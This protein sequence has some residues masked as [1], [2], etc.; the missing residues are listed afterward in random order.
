MT[1]G[2]AARV[3]LC[4]PS[5]GSP[6]HVAAPIEDIRDEMR[7]VTRRNEAPQARGRR[8][9]DHG[10]GRHRPLDPHD[11]DITP[12]LEHRKRDQET[13]ERVLVAV[14]EFVDID[15]ELPDPGFIREKRDDARAFPPTVCGLQVPIDNRVELLAA[16]QGIRIALL[17]DATQLV[18]TTRQIWNLTAFGLT[19]TG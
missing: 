10:R 17:A 11:V 12:R 13:E 1:T 15:R 16:R 6:V 3:T 14:P 19:A 7:A 5:T 18:A 9:R 2:T 8:K 4:G